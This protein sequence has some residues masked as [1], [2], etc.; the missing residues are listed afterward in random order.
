MP[1]LDPYVSQS[2]LQG[3]Q[4]VQATPEMF[5]G[6][7]ARALMNV[8]NEA[9]RTS[10]IVNSVDEAKSRLRA[11][12][13][14]TTMDTSWREKMIAMQNDPEFTT[15]YGEDGS[16]FAD[17]FKEEFELYASEQIAASDV[18][19]RKYIEQ[20]MYNLGESLMGSAMQFQAEVGSAF[21]SDTLTKSID[22]GTLSARLSPDQYTSILANAT[23]AVNTAAN[24]DPTIR[25]RFSDKAIQN[26]TSGAALGRLEKG[27]VLAANQIKNGSMV[28]MSL[29]EAGVPVKKTLR[30]LVDADTFETLSD[31]ADTVIKKAKS[32][33]EQAR[34]DIKSDITTM[35]ELAETPDDFLAAQ[36]AIVRNQGI[37]KHK[38]KNELRVK[39][40]KKS[41]ELREDYDSVDRGNAF[42]SGDAYLNPSMPDSMKDYNNYYNKRV[43][44]VL[45][46]MDDTKRNTFLTDLVSK[47]KVIPDGLK[48]NL[49]SAARSTDP[50][51]VARAAD[52][53]D[54]IRGTNPHV[55]A[56]FPQRDLARIDMVN[57]KIASGLSPKTAMEQVDAALDVS[58]SA[59]F[60]QRTTQLK[61]AKLDYQSLA[62]QNFNASWYVKAL[63][64]GSGSI[65]DT[66][67]EMAT[68]QIAQV[69]TEYRAAY[70]T[71]YKL[72][73]DTVAAQKYANSVVSGSYGVTNINGKNQLMRF[74]PEKYF[75]IDNVDNDWMRSQIEEEAAKAIKD[76]WVDPDRP[77]KPEDAILIPAPHVTPRTA[78]E[79]RPVYKMMALSPDGGYIDL[80]GPNKY[81][82]F[83]KDKKIGELVGE[84]REEGAE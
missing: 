30:E 70:E 26:I 52:L 72:T 80:L 14:L 74:A 34:T 29:D 42:A 9:E 65:E 8:S 49:Q 83:D 68:R 75:G 43:A 46:D 3:T 36:D 77:I 58:N 47:S 7:S 41:K 67:S 19:D 18:R 73:G 27:G 62:L 71:Q 12:N 17:S 81:F 16:M 10:E 56:D 13:H 64:G 11:A 57:S 45:S 76:T 1:R 24:I 31:Q 15:K 51:E 20:G 79:G 23:L 84:A 44:P 40:F 60:E 22:N 53:I 82:T 59:V 69:S 2:R 61:E 5:G 33:A 32:E 48:G 39:L 21:A 63:P 54:R 78:K 66:S 38:E 50:K 35:I 4:N 55:L 6:Q 28:F 25:R 37:F